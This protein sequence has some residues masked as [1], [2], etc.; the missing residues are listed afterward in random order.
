MSTFPGPPRSWLELLKLGPGWLAWHHYVTVHL[1]AP[2]RN[3]RELPPHGWVF[4]LIIHK[5]WQTLAVK[6]VIRKDYLGSFP[7]PLLPGDF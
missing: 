6:G 3:D 5:I 4:S 1:P 7:H 2:H